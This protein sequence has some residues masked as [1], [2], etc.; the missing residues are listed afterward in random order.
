M[1]SSRSSCATNELPYMHM[2][3]VYT[4]RYDIYT[5]IYRYIY[6]HPVSSESHTSPP[7]L[8]YIYIE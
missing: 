3:V 2:N 4:R 6:T 7:A 8:F 1:Y 5:Y